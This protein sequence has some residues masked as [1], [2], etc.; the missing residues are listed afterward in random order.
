MTYLLPPSWVGTEW[1]QDFPQVPMEMLVSQLVLEVVS[2]CY[3]QRPPS[4]SAPQD[5]VSFFSLLV[6]VTFSTGK[7][8]FELPVQQACLKTVLLNM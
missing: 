2:E 6:H 7:L 1:D 8:W 4:Q 5:I 3:P